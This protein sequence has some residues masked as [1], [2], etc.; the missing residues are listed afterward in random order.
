MA[1][2]SMTLA[3]AQKPI[4]IPVDKTTERAFVSPVSGMDPKC[5]PFN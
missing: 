3:L 2:P 4:G 1:A 5:I